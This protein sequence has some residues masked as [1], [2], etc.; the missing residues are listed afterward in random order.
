MTP[1]ECAQTS[2]QQQQRIVQRYK[3]ASYK[4][5]V[6]RQSIRGVRDALI[7]G[8][9]LQLIVSHIEF[10]RGVRVWPRFT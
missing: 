2:Q 6:K 9:V 3:I 10:V 1:R 7:P 8:K 4:K 5:L